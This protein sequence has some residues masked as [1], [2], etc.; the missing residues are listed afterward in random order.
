MKALVV[1]TVGTEGRRE[2]RLWVLMVSFDSSASG[3]GWAALAV[4]CSGSSEIGSCTGLKARRLK[5]FL[6]TRPA[7]GE[8][9]MPL[10]G[11]GL[12]RGTAGGAA[13]I[14]AAEAPSSQTGRALV[15]LLSILLLCT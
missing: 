8:A 13:W 15:L 2:I 7:K 4:L 10:F 11:L 1:T 12:G 5:G 9:S 14:A 6:L 3:S